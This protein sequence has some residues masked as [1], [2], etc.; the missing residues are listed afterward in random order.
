MRDLRVSSL[1]SVDNAA[2][3]D[4]WELH[5]PPA[6]SVTSGKF[7]TTASMH[8]AVT[9]NVDR[10]PREGVQI[11]AASALSSPGGGYVV[12]EGVRSQGV[13]TWV[14]S[15]LGTGPN[16][17]SL[18]RSLADAGI[19]HFATSLVGDVGVGVTMVEGDGKAAMVIASGVESEPSA[20]ILSR[21]Q[22]NVGDLV[23]VDG[24]D[25]TGKVGAETL[26]SW[27][28]DLPE[29]VT[30]VFSVSPEVGDV[31]ADV[32]MRV[33]K[34]TDVL[35][36]NVREAATLT[37]VLNSAVPGTGVRHVLRPEAAVVRRTGPLGCEVDTSVDAGRIQLPAFHTKPVDTT[38]VGD[39]HV[40]VMC[41]SLL[42]GFD[43]PEAC[44]RANAGAALVLS[45]QTAF[46]LP[47]IKEVETVLEEGAVPVALTQR[48]SADAQ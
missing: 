6:P 2:E 24:A 26:A 39:V 20:E 16:S 44:R 35:T 38:G 45:H 18:R 41:A 17:H 13:E 33:L 48:G 47:T 10:I 36:M 31:P 1:C 25:L 14:A 15:P 3:E 30:L 34:R 19:R 11:R 43:L 27:I 42:L 23:H 5:R 29:G 40:A 4:V 37:D 32:L 12:A 8:L 9:L 22:L 7:V 28:E 21:L 46:P